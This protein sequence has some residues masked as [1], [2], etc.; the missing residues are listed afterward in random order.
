M[1]SGYLRHLDSEGNNDANVVTFLRNC[2][3]EQIKLHAVITVSNENNCK[4]L[5]F[6]DLRTLLISY[7]TRTGQEN[8]A[9][10]NIQRLKTMTKRLSHSVRCNN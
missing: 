3:A 10:K 7:M 5:L 8:R 9:I 1:C 4:L 2:E 6:T